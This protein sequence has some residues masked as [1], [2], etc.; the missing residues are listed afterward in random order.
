MIMQT[1]ESKI[2][3]KVRK[4]GR[5]TLFS[6]SDFPSFGDPKSVL[7]ALERMVASGKIIRV[8]R[9][10]YC[11]PKIDKVLGLGVICPSFE[12]VAQYIAKRDR[13]RIVPTG[14]Y[15]L[16]VLGLSTQVPANVV[17]L[18]DGMPRKVKLLSGRGITFVKTA[19]RNLAFTNRLAMLL[20]FAL[21]EI[22]EG[23]V[24]EEQKRHI[25]GL[26]KNEDRAA[27]ERDYPLMPA[28]VQVLIMKLY[29]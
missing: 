4:C 3:D 24:A 20:T 25:L 17:Y 28:W 2:Y 9:G 15:A 22:G 7:K 14:S 16:N 12:D 23:N 8:A 1:I 26:L 27:I 10:I 21:K 19:P 18:T 11:Y 13:A 6:S 29:E 5:G